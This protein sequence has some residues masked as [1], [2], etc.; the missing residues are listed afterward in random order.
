MAPGLLN[1]CA[2]IKFKMFDNTICCLVFGGKQGVHDGKCNNAEVNTL[3]GN[4]SK[5][6]IAQGEGAKIRVTLNISKLIVVRRCG[7]SEFHRYSTLYLNIDTQ[8]ISYN[9]LVKAICKAL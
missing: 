5:M 8:V 2:L 6:E 4:E 9:N 1:V 7:I 3:W